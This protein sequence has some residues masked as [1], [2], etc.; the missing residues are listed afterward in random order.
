MKRRNF[1]GAVAATTV[2]AGC[3]GDEYESPTPTP[4]ESGT[5]PKY[6]GRKSHKG[7]KIK[8]IE[9]KDLMGPTTEYTFKIGPGATHSQERVYMKIYLYDKDENLIETRRE[10]VG[11]LD[12]PI[13]ES[14]GLRDDESDGFKIEIWEMKE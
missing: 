6:L 10:G 9:T 4:T 3:T 2:L 13:L 14:I 5:G 7:Y 11:V 1:L 8:L 12:G